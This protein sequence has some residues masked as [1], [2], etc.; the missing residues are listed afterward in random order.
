MI[1]LGSGLQPVVRGRPAGPGRAATSKATTQPAAKLGAYESLPPQKLL[2]TL[3][4]LGMSELAQA[5][6]SD[7]VASGAS[8]VSDLDMVAEAKTALA[9]GTQDIEARNALLDDGIALR[10]RIVEMTAGASITE[11]Q[12][13]HFRYK[14]KLADLI[15]RLRPEPYALRLLYLRGS[16]DDANTIIDLTGQAIKLLDELGGPRGEI[17]KAVQALRRN[18]KD[19]VVY[20]PDMEDLQRTVKYYSAWV[21]LYRGMALPDAGKEGEEKNRLLRS[22]IVNA[23]PLALDPEWGVQHWAKLLI[24]RASRELHEY[25]SAD[26]AFDEVV[27]AKDAERDAR[28]DALF[29]HVRNLAEYGL[30]EVNRKDGSLQAGEAKFK[31]AEQGLEDFRKGAMDILGQSGKVQVDLKVALLADYLYQAWG[32]CY[33]DAKKVEE[34]QSKAQQALL[35][36]IIAHPQPEM[37]TVFFEII[38]P[39]YRS[40]KDYDKLSSVVLI[41]V[42]GYK[43][44]L[45]TE[46]AKAEAEECLDEILRRPEGSEDKTVEQIVKPIALAR[47]GL[48]Q[49]QRKDRE[50]AGDDFLRIAEKYPDHPQAFNSALNAVISYYAAI[51]QCTKDRVPVPASLREK[52]VSAA[53]LLLVKK[54]EWR[55]RPQAAPWLFDLA[56]QCDEMTRVATDEQEKVSWGRKAADYYGK[57]PKDHSGYMYARHL[58]LEL[59]VQL[60]ATMTDAAKVKEAAGALT[61]ELG[62]YSVEARQAADTAKTAN[63]KDKFTDLMTWGGRAAFQAAAIQYDVLG[64]PAEALRRLAN[65]PAEWPDTPVLEESAEFEIRALIKQKDTKQALTKF[66]DFVE[67]H[68]KQA[69][70]LLQLLISSTRE[71]VKEVQDKLRKDP[72]S[73]ALQEDLATYR[74]AYLQLAQKAMG[75]DPAAVPE[76]RRYGLDQLL[77]DALLENGDPNGAI[78]VYDDAIA[79]EKK[80]R[81]ALEEAIDKEYEEKIK[82]LASGDQSFETLKEKQGEFQQVKDGKKRKEKEGEGTSRLADS[83]A[84]NLLE[85]S[86]TYLEAAPRERARLAQAIDEF[87]K[88]YEDQR[89]RRKKLLPSDWAN[90]YG[91]A[92][93]HRAMKDYAKAEEQYLALTRGIDPAHPRYWEMHLEYFQCA[94]EGHK[95]DG[96]AME[97]LGAKVRELR[98]LDPRFGGLERQFYSVEKATS[99]PAP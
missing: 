63:E 78:K 15:G 2:E 35:S 38:G 55:K 83:M 57:V 3:R 67:K 23:E 56:R 41:A 44:T 94:M 1:V 27:G 62:K 14:F 49:S 85:R 24:G 11:E 75:P 6:V 70:R 48:A 69:P 13:K 5:L 72:T 51:D 39:K 34:R 33:K 95:G 59:R 30:Y 32:A 26:K 53:E 20:G 29:E 7:V 50:K 88:A 97:R 77:G 98:M 87:R 28:V 91:L 36:F 81:K 65:L 42:A 90:T 92:R 31:E 96:K 84:S 76:E 52:F 64:Q 16:Q 8:S 93:S 86:M 73:S 9:Q 54:E 60:L 61:Q 79:I 74:S 66:Q 37:Q 99:Q 45:N 18:L 22:A 82:A 68:E 40:R 19:W 80:R 47:R 10:K 71:R 21:Y 17:P 4:A 12:V 89:D 46:E 25:K 58:E 43:Q